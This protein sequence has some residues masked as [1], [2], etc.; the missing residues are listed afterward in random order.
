VVLRVEE[1]IGL[2]HEQ[3]IAG[4]GQEA[5]TSLL[6]N[7]L[8]EVACSLSV[9]ALIPLDVISGIEENSGFDDGSSPI[10]RSRCR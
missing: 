10:P 3:P 6:L 4:P 7:R 2:I 5:Q 9:F 8:H 1:L